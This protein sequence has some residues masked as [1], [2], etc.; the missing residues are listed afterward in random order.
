[1]SADSPSWGPWNFAEPLATI[2]DVLQ[3][4]NLIPLLITIL[5]VVVVYLVT[6]KLLS[7]FRA[8]GLISRGTEE[9]V[10]IGALLLSAFIVITVAISSWLQMYAASILIVAIIV[11]IIGTG[12]YTVRTYVENSISYVLFV[13]S[14]VIKDGDFVRIDVGGKIYEGRIS[15]VEGSYATIDTPNSRVYIPYSVLLRS[16]I[17]KVTRYT[18]GF[19]LKINGQNL[20]LDKVINELKEILSREMKMMVKEGL[21]VKPIEIRDDEIVLQVSIEVMNP[22]NISECYETLARVLP[23]KLPYRFSIEF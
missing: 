20:E 11:L 13:S 5:C 2:T 12:I 17:T 16:I 3:Q 6:R 4:L 7:R 15:M 19:K 14:N 9:A 10:K 23:R 8:K 18:F 22:R 21:D 1:M